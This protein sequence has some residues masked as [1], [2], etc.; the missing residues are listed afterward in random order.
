LIL[1]KKVESPYRKE[2]ETEEADIIEDMESFGIEAKF[3]DTWVKTWDTTIN[4]GMPEEIRIN[5]GI[6]IKGRKVTL[7]DISSPKIGRKIL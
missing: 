6:T 4:K 5:L 2:E 7:S 1:F 3:N